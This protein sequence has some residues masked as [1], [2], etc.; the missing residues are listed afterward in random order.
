MAAGDLLSLWGEAE[1]VLPTKSPTR[2]YSD[3]MHS[4]RHAIQR[5]LTL[6]L[7]S[8]ADAY[9]RSARQILN[10]PYAGADAAAL[11]APMYR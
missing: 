10:D 11:D 1:H 8:N 5:W 7:V 4:G 2:W 6:G 9:G 3:Q